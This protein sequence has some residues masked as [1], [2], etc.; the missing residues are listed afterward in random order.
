[1][2]ENRVFVT[3][4]AGRWYS[5]DRDALRRELAALAPQPAPAPIPGVRA[6]IVPHAGYAYSGQVA[7]AA[8]ARFDP[9]R[10]DR[11]VVLGP[12][13]S[14]ALRDCVSVLDVA[15][16]RTPLGD[17]PAD[18]DFARRLLATPFAIVEPR[19]HAREHSDQIQIPL[20]QTVFAGLPLR[21]VSLVCGGFGD[22]AAQAF[23]QT[24]RGM[25][26]S[27]TLLVVSTDFTHYGPNFDYVPFTD[28][29]SRRLRELD[30]RVFERVAAGDAAGFRQVL[31]ET[32]ATV[33]GENPLTI[34]IAVAGPGAMVTEIAYDQ[35]GRMTGDWENSVS[36][37]SAWVAW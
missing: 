22:A 37:L 29:V 2:N 16:I 5:D 25:L 27:R 1:M 14:V 11:A 18:P 21:V 8:Y 35:S 28:N 36:Y 6:V 31:Q 3:P 15:H 26:D 9:G 20:L 32:G 12:S 23:G 33:C 24:L 19:A 10:Y 13:H 7:M 17:C 30:H 34:A 4:L